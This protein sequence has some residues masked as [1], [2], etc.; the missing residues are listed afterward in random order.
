MF[1]CLLLLSA[2]S[3]YFHISLLVL[4]QLDPI[5]QGRLLF[6]RCS[7]TWGPAWLPCCGEAESVPAILYLAGYASVPRGKRSQLLAFPP[8]NFFHTEPFSQC[9]SSLVKGVGDVRRGWELCVEALILNLFCSLSIINFGERHFEL[10][11]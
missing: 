4:P 7:S 3:F 5:P 2:F 1:Y 11:V 6:S 9:L 10:Y 8:T